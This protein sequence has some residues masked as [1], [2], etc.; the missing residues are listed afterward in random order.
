MATLESRGGLGFGLR[1]KG[2]WGARKLGVTLAEAKSTH[3][4][5]EAWKGC[6]SCSDRG[7]GDGCLLA[8]AE[9]RVTGEMMDRNYGQTV[10]GG[11]FI[12]LMVLWH[13]W[14]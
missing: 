9:K 12:I 2:F 7:V 8:T 5:W 1:C 11:Q 10:P 14:L 6:R 4:T 13:V 3:A